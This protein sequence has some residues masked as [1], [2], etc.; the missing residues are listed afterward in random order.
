[1]RKTENAALFLILSIIIYSCNKS[2]VEEVQVPPVVVTDA[3]LHGWIKSPRGTATLQFLQGATIPFL[4]T[5][6][7]QYKTAD[8]S[9]SKLL[10]TE[11][12]GTLM[13]SITG[14]SYSGLVEQRDS[15]VDANSLIL[16]VDTDG[17]N[18]SDFHL[19][20][21][22][23]YQTGKF[24]AGTL[25]PDQGDSKMKIWQTWDAFRGGW[26]LFTSVQTDPDHGGVVESFPT[27]VNKYP[28]AKIVN[29]VMVAGVKTVSGCF[30]VQA[31][32][33]IFSKNFIGYVD[34]IKIGV[35]GVSTTYDFE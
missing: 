8:K 34:N 21:E 20:F 24:V 9:F 19:V 31:G 22:P 10:N 6:S 3:N 11:F 29:E 13:S 1:M 16:E 2:P 33:P 18:L 5:G 23:R 27:F 25:L 12:G 17:D 35:N 4:G 28:N 15:T 30:R 7:I 32:G 26:F 14:L